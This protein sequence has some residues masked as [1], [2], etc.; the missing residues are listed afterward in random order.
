MSIESNGLQSFQQGF[1]A[2]KA[3]NSI[4]N[5]PGGHL[6]VQRGNATTRGQNKP[7]T[8]RFG[9]RMAQMDITHHNQS[10]IHNSYPLIIKESGYNGD[11]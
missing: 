4:A 5:S 11:F 6:Y 9:T 2:S 3:S 1:A 10:L 7:R 8:Q